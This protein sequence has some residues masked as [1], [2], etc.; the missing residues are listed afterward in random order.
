MKKI[1]LAHRSIEKQIS[2]QKKKQ[3]CLRNSTMQQSFNRELI[4]SLLHFQR[5][6]MTSKPFNKNIIFALIFHLGTPIT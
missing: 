2:V 6:F 1:N 3:V 5:K 4:I